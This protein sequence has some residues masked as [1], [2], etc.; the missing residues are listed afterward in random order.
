MKE[1]V[2]WH[3]YLFII[4]VL[5]CTELYQADCYPYLGVIGIERIF[6]NMLLDPELY[7]EFNFGTKLFRIHYFGIDLNFISSS[8]NL[9]RIQINKASQIWKG[10]F[11][12]KQCFML[13]LK[14]SH[15]FNLLS[16]KN[17][18]DNQWINN[19]KYFIALAV[20]S[21]NFSLKHRIPRNI[22]SC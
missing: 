3:I 17:P 14:S 2:P 11:A 9:H 19:S 22:L 18:M 5:G 1:Y 10:M 4:G 21:L 8:K 7:N 12:L 20:K 16:S 13:S 6:V 15:L